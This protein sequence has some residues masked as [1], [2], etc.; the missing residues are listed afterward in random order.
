MVDRKTS[1]RGIIARFMVFVGMN[2]NGNF[3]KGMREASLDL[4]KMLE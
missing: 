4:W 2:K 1:G 3:V